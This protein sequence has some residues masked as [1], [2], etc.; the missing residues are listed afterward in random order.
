MIISDT[1]KFIFIHVPKCAGTSI[2][3]SLYKYDTRNNFFWNYVPIAPASEE[4]GEPLLVDKGHM[5]L[6][7]WRSLYPD[8]YSLINEYTVFSISRN[9]IS[10]LLSGFFEPRD[11]LYHRLCKD[12]QK[13]KDI[14]DVNYKFSCYIDEINTSANFLKQQYVHNTPQYLYTLDGNKLIH[15]INITLE[16]PENGLNALKTILPEIAGDVRKGLTSQKNIRES[17]KF[18]FL[19]DQLKVSAKMTFVEKFKK[20]FDLFGYAIPEF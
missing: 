20:D 17:Q 14:E 9:P 15:D 1:H 7:V 5:T 2:R 18:L 8:A 3:Q 6:G 16:D 11:I 13:T 4:E 10:R 19:W 12:N